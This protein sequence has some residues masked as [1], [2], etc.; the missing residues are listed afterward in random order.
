MR[1]S[2]GRIF[3]ASFLLTLAVIGPL[4]GL[5][6]FWG[7]QQNRQAVQTQQAQSGVPIQRPGSL[8]LLLAVAG[9]RPAFVL[10]RLDGASPAFRLV[11]VPGET[12]VLDG[13]GQ[14]ITLAESYAAAGPAR[15]GNLLAA[16]LGIQ[17]DRYLA[18][19]P[20]VWGQSLSGLGQ[21]RVN[22]SPLLDEAQRR[23]LGVAAVAQLDA[24]EAV[25]LLQ[26]TNLTGPPLGRLRA[27]V[28]QAFA[29]QSQGSLAEAVPQGL[30]RCSGDLLT[31]LTA[32][33]LEELGR[34]LA[35]LTDASCSPQADLLPG[36]WDERTAR[37]ELEED[38]LTFAQ[39]LFPLAPQEAGTG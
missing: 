33:D 6:A 17:L 7:V 34:V 21:A 25:N 26:G 1:A 30:R 12:V 2:G 35:Q 23:A 4:L 13:Q 15:A 31:D 3:W 16:T 11:V 9:E 28:W 38:A 29:L 14:P 20:A 5:F 18:A 37:Y 24:A 22:L 10:A 32:L 36:R 39:A 8:S 27:A 19:T